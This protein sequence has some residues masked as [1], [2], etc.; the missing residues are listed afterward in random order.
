ME[1]NTLGDKVKSNSFLKLLIIL[2]AYGLMLNIIANII[3]GFELS[4][5]NVIGFGLLWHFV[6]NE[7]PLVF[8][9]YIGDIR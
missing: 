6:S 7:F 1:K 5:M 8:R 3:L 9:K 2:I 4:L